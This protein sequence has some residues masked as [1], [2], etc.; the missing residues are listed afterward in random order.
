[1]SL[2][3]HLDELRKRIVIS[4][5]AVCVGAAASWFLYETVFNLLTNPFCDF[6]IRHPQLADDPREPCK[7]AYFNVTDAFFLRLKVTFFLGFV[8]ALPVVL[9]EL[10]AFIT[11]GLTERERKFA[12]PF[13]L[14]SVILFALGGW[15]AFLTL[16]RGLNFLLG[17]AGSERVEFVLSISKYLGFVMLIIMAFGISFEFP[18]I[19]ISLTFVG[20]LSSQQLRQWRRY[21]LVLTAIF[22]AIITPSA[23]FFTML[24]LMVPLLVFYELAILVSRL[25]KR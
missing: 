22:A 1:M 17:F 9:Y 14:S 21:V 7:L 2:V 19:L 5:V 23:D 4:V 13:V 3:E 18:L 11:P 25:M 6:M 24:A 8:L 15:F 10:W 20:I 12:L 16:P